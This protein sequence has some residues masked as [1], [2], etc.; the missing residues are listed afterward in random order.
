MFCVCYAVWCEGSAEDKAEEEAGDEAEQIAPLCTHPHTHLELI[1]VD[2][3]AAVC[4][5][6]LEDDVCVLF[7]FLHGSLVLRLLGR[8]AHLLHRGALVKEDESVLPWTLPRDETAHGNRCQ[9]M[10]QI[11]VHCVVVQR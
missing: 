8:Q 11:V 6:H 10:L 4:I 7:A 2:V 9:P 1:P 3:S 5:E